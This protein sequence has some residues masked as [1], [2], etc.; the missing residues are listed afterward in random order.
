MRRFGPKDSSHLA[1]YILQV[2]LDPDFHDL[3]IHHPVDGDAS[4]RHLPTG[5]G[6]AH[7]LPLVGAVIHETVGH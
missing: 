6:Y 5:R 3:A 1:H 2:P 7:E 4:E